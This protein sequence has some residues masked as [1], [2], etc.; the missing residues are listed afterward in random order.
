MRKKNFIGRTDCA[1]IPAIQLQ[2]LNISI[3]ISQSELDSE[4]LLKLAEM[5]TESYVSLNKKQRFSLKIFSLLF[6]S[7]WENLS[8]MRL[9]I[10]EKAQ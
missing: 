9:T 4:F 7:Q 3:Q 6:F 8:Y 1:W 5:M 10:T 2:M